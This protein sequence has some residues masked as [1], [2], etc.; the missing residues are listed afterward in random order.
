MTQRGQG[1]PG[2]LGPLGPGCGHRASEPHRQ[3]E[4]CSAAGKEPAKSPNEV[5]WQEIRTATEPQGG[6]QGGRKSAEGGRDWAYPGSP[7]AA[8]WPRGPKGAVCAIS[9]TRPIER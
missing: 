8:A 6:A 5:S 3:A 4:S 7:P 1:S 9:P 2:R